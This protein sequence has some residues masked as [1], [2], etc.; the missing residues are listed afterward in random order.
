MN[1][2]RLTTLLVAGI[3][4]TALAWASLGTFTVQAQEKPA[5]IARAHSADFGPSFE[6]PIFILMLGSD[7]RKGNPERSQGGGLHD[8]IH[9][10]A[11][12]PATKKASI[13]GIPRDS[14]V[15]IPGRGRSK[16]NSAS[17]G[18][19]DL[20]IRTVEDLSGCRF[21]Y[22]TLVG[23][24]GFR[25]IVDDLGGITFTVKSSIKDRFA[26]L[27]V[28]PGE[29]VFDGAT[30]LGW[31]RSRKDSRSR[32][33]GDFDRSREQG[34]LMVAAL[35]EARKDGASDAGVALRALGTLRRNLKLNIPLDEA[36]KLGLLMLQIDPDD[37]RNIVLDGEIAMEGSQ[38]IV[39]I[40]DA[41][42]NELVDICDDGQLGS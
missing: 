19:P 17:L 9:I 18:G 12:D 32:P 14:Y 40:T 7:A 41:G 1:T 6:K 10:V 29:Q 15:D 8:S 3:S 38:S 24:E 35:R 13:V 34:N 37:V 30:A 26:K 36:F 31:S 28:K 21:D 2:R 39:R 16:I 22:Y 11:I 25:R 27:D 33:R 23:F 20:M 5:K 42:R 4:A